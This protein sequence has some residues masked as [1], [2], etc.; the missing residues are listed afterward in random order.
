MKEINGE[1]T[2][3]VIPKR[4]IDSRIRQNEIFAEKAGSGGREAEE[5]TF[6]ELLALL[7]DI[8]KT[9]LIIR[10]DEHRYYRFTE[11]FGVMIKTQKDIDQSIKRPLEH[12]LDSINLWLALVNFEKVNSRGKGDTTRVEHLKGAEQAYKNVAELIHK[13]HLKD[14]EEE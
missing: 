9:S 12:V 3:Y 11:P 1:S 7:H 5:K 6:L 8:Q 13:V 14:T 4:F 2:F 10:A